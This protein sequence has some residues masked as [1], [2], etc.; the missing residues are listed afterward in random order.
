MAQSRISKIPLGQK[1][2]A[3]QYQPVSIFKS[4]TSIDYPNMKIP[5]QLQPACN[6][7]AQ[8]GIFVQMIAKSFMSSQELK[9]EHEIGKWQQL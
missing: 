5:F 6:A 2:H 8:K 9:K 7:D 3:N 4:L 1:T